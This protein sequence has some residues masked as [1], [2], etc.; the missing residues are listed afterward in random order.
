MRFVEVQCQGPLPGPDQQ[1]NLAKVLGRPTASYGHHHQQRHEPLGLFERECRGQKARIL[2]EP[3]AA[4]GMLL[5]FI[6]P[7]DLLG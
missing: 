6:A 1:M 7:A 2:K 4:F 5:A 3:K